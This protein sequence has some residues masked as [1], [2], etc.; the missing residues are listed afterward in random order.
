ME[1]KT[2]TPVFFFFNNFYSHSQ[3]L[4]R[5]FFSSQGD[6][7]RKKGT[8]R[9]ANKEWSRVTDYFSKK[10]NEKLSIRFEKKVRN[11]K[12]KMPEHLFSAFLSQFPPL[13]FR[14]ITFPFCNSS[15][16]CISMENRGTGTRRPL[17]YFLQSKRV[18]LSTCAARYQLRVIAFRKWISSGQE[19][20]PKILFFFFSFSRENRENATT[21][22]LNKRITSFE[23]N[24]NGATRREKEIK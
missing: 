12:R 13:I 19:Q 6:G 1:V 21:R 16:W 10:R 22:F 18:N 11:V 23:N 20:I 5:L 2:R 15:R 3:S 9:N 7:R 4:S 24:G 14:P 17:R 8:K